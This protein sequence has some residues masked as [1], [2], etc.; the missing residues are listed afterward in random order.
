M[1]KLFNGIRGIM[2]AIERHR[3]CNPKLCLLRE[4]VMLRIQLL[5]NFRLAQWCTCAAPT[6]QGH[7]HCCGAWSQE[8][9]LAGFL[10][11]CITAYTFYRQQ[12]PPLDARMAGEAYAAQAALVGGSNA[13]G[14]GSSGSAYSSLELSN[15]AHA[16]LPV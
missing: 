6:S 2:D 10:L 13:G 8:D 14:S 15:G 3:E 7:R 11:G 9:V 12:Y 4:T 16:D 5:S 1:R